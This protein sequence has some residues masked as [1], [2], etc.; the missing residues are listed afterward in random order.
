MTIVRRKDGS[1]SGACGLLSVSPP[2]EHHER[3]T[4]ADV[5]TIQ[6]C[7]TAVMRSIPTDAFAYIFQKLYEH[8]QKCVVKNGD[9]FE[10]Q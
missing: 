6:E 7:V 1:R 8:Y 4:F 10:G 2:E 3:R 9:Y 5:A